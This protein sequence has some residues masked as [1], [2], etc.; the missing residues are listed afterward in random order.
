MRKEEEV[1]VAEMAAN[2]GKE[3]GEKGGGKERS[4]GRGKS[5]VW[6]MHTVYIP[7]HCHVLHIYTYIHVCVPLPSI[8]PHIAIVRLPSSVCPA[9]RT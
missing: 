2:E 5:K 4:K 6:D 7:T 3:R 1:A 8:P 9:G